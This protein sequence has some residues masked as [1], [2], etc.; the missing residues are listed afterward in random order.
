MFEC[1]KST[2]KE[3]G[4]EQNADLVA[5]LEENGQRS[6]KKTLES[7]ATSQRS[8][9]VAQPAKRNLLQQNTDQ[10]ADLQTLNT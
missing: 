6:T 7:K 2:N 4:Q 8:T 10:S 1:K 3:L 9:I 5:S